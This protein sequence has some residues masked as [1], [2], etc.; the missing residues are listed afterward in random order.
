ML[1]IMVVE[2]EFLRPGGRIVRGI[3]VE[4]HGGRRV[5]VA[6]DAVCSQRRR[7]PR[8]VLPVHTVCK[9]RAG[10]GTREVLLWSQGGRSTPS[11]H[12]GSRRRR[13]AAWPS[14]EP[15]AM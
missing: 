5:R 11:V 10:R 2:R 12:R 7:E 6:R 13:L 14:A 9:P 4:H 3:E 1:L 8:E 15:E